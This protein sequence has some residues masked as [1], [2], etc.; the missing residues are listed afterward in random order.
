MLWFGF[1][2]RRILCLG[3]YYDLGV[4]THRALQLL[5]QPPQLRQ[6]P[7]SLPLPAPPRR[8]RPPRRRPVSVSRLPGAPARIRS[9]RP[10]AAAPG[11]RR[12]RVRFLGPGAGRPRGVAE[13][14]GGDGEGVEEGGGAEEAAA[15]DEDAGEALKLRRADG[16]ARAGAG[17]GVGGEHLPGLVD[18][19]V[20]DRSVYSV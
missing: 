14:K 9:A 15:D 18:G 20:A 2:M 11:P 16:E 19:E 17:D 5:Q 7:C 12:I 8:V 3:A 6:H 13:M 1:S 4:G 10:P